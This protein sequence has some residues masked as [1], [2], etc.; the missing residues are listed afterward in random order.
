[1]P[2]KT[3]LNR[4]RMN[5]ILTSFLFVGAV[6]LLG[7][8]QSC[9]RGVSL[10]ETD[11]KDMY[12]SNSEVPQ[13]RFKVFHS[14]STETEIY[15]MFENRGLSYSQNS[16]TQD[17]MSQVRIAWQ[18]YSDYSS[19]EVL[20]SSSFVMIDTIATSG[21]KQLQ[22]NFKVNMDGGYNFILK[23]T[24]TDL[25]NNQKTVSFIHINKTDKT[26]RQFFKVVLKENNSVLFRNYFYAGEKLEI[27]YSPSTSINQLQGKHFKIIFPVAA[28]PF[29]MSKPKAFDFSNHTKFN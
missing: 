23:V 15:F 16:A 7:L 24:T 10:S 9:K 22:G 6:L 25:N 2:L 27:H 14:S 12:S 13:P 20:D 8:N 4:V 18:L 19:K 1:M 26:N 17:L 21:L 28:P 3:Q 29:S 11:F 5:K